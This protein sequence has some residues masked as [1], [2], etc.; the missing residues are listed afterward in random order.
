MKEVNKPSVKLKTY[1]SE[2]DYELIA[3]LEKECTQN[4]QTTLKLELDYKLGV[5]LSDTGNLDNKEINEFLYFNG[6][7]LIGYIG[8]CGFG[9]AGTPLEITGMVHPEHRRKGIFTKLFELVMAECQKRNSDG[10]LLLCDRKS[11]SGQGFLKRNGADYKYSEFEMYLMAEVSAV[12]Q[13]HMCGITLRKAVN[14]DA[15]EIA[16]QNAI[17]FSDTTE[18]TN[19]DLEENDSDLVMPEE[20]EKRGMTIYLAEK[21]KQIV[22]KVHM[23]I[24]AAIS[25]IYGLG[26]LPEF[27]GKGFGRAILLSA[28]KKLKESQTN[29]IMLQVA[30]ENATALNL[31]NSCGFKETSVMDYFCLKL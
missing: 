6:Q 17:Y 15:R 19:S 9:G 7:K 10:V 5:A 20:E 23:Q 29:T 3:A 30:A 31:Y 22:G 13:E 4:D 12:S 14:F 21:D 1:L 8:I 27:R 24:N 25:G 28:V 2:K 16:R 11:A 26:V 18:F